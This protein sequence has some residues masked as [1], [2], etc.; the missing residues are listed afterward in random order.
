MAS[1]DH[2]KLTKNMFEWE[3]LKILNFKNFKYFNW[4]FL[5]FKILCLNKKN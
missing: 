5:F 4:I 3:N 1:T 2:S